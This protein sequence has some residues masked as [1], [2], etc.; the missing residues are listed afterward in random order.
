M[1]PV[2]SSF[3]FLLARPSRGASGELIG[4]S[5]PRK[6]VWKESGLRAKKKSCGENEE[7]ESVD[8]WRKDEPCLDSP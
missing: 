1:I 8:N 6:R 4:D 5:P 7:E 2:E 3:V